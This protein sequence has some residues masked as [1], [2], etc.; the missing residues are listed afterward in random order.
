MLNLFYYLFE[1][2]TLY[3]EKHKSQEK[4]NLKIGQFCEISQECKFSESA[5]QLEKNCNR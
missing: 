4:N 5:T 1:P 2:F 3:N